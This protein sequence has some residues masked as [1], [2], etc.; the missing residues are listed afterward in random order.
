MGI[1]E[2]ESS[3]QQGDDGAT[4]DPKDEVKKILYYS[5]CGQRPGSSGCHTKKHDTK[6]FERK[7]MH[8]APPE[9]EA[10]ATHVVF[11]H[12]SGPLRVPDSVMKQLRKKCPRMLLRDQTHFPEGFTVHHWHKFFVP[13]AQGETIFPSDSTTRIARRL[14]LR[15][16]MN[17]LAAVLRPLELVWDPMRSSDTIR[18]EGPRAV[19]TARCS[20]QRR[21]FMLPPGDAVWKCEV[22]IKG[23]AKLQFGLAGADQSE[24]VL[25]I[26]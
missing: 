26:S 22:T 10:S 12:G 24:R 21:L 9:A 16:Q 6:K 5:C 14:A 23:R 19:A 7:R 13:F 8:H 11:I 2:H 25:T 4:T 20:E 15:A 18:C 1:D 3:E 17:E